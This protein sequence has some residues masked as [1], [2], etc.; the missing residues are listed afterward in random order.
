MQTIRRDQRPLIETANIESDVNDGAENV[1]IA[2]LALFRKTFGPLVCDQTKVNE[3]LLGSFDWLP[4]NVTLAP[5]DT[6]W[7]A[8]AMATGIELAPDP[9]R[10]V[11]VKLRNG[12]MV[13][14]TG[15]FRLIPIVSSSS[16]IPSSINDRTI[17]LGSP[18]PAAQL[19]VVALPPR[20]SAPGVALLTIPMSTLAAP[21][22]LPLRFNTAT[23][24][25]KPRSA[26]A[27][28][29]EVKFISDVAPGSLI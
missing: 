12:P 22:A 3:S 7:L 8:P 25:A 9:S 13:V 19:I 17:V 2:E 23:T 16:T 18:S 10:M 28:P 15:L 4:S 24:V 21:T 11:A 6:L 1:A 27:A 14:F 26:A 29:D 5:A 20:K